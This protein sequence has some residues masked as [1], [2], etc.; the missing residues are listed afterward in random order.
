[1]ARLA[2]VREQ[3]SSIEKTRA[4][5]KANPDATLTAVAKLAKCSHSTVVNAREDLAADARRK[6]RETARPNAAWTSAP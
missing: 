2:S 3:I 6:L 1:M 5:L 4:A